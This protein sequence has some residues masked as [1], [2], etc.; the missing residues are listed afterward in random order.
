M[1][2]AE[3]RAAIEALHGHYFGGRILRVSEAK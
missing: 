3:A 1:D 2:D